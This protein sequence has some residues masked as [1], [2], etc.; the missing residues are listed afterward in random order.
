[1]EAFLQKLREQAIYLKVES[2]QKY[3]G[4][5]G[6]DD[7]LHVLENLKKSY[8][9]FV[10]IEYD[11]INTQTDQ[12][13]LKKIREGLSQENTLVI[14]DLKFSSFESAVAPDFVTNRHQIPSIS[15]MQDW[16]LDAFTTY[17]TLV[18]ESDYNEDGFLKK[19]ESRYTPEQRKRI[20]EPVI[21]GILKRKNTSVSFKNRSD[22]RPYKLQLPRQRSVEILT[23]ASPKVVD[24]MEPR[25]SMARV[26]IRGQVARPKVLELFEDIKT[27][28]IGYEKIA[29]SEKTYELKYPIYCE[30][31]T[32]DGLYFLEN[33][34]FGLYSAGNTREEAEAG[35]FEEFEFIL[36]RYNSL[37]DSQLTDDVIS[38]KQSLNLIWQKDVQSHVLKRLY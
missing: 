12:A 21:N 34:Q 2:E 18:I 31:N 19:I 6:I 29:G 16:K 28:I 37:P 25:T 13:K 20:Y 4:G 7:V 15:N 35:L 36:N 17:K 24:K 3:G 5:V 10:Q 11:R 38:I 23:P 32:A 22:D 8:A 14:V 26:E 33:K 9:E 27:P 1:M 30:M